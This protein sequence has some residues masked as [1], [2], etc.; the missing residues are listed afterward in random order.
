M[1][2]LFLCSSVKL[3]L[4]NQGLPQPVQ[5]RTFNSQLLVFDKT[6]AQPH[7]AVVNGSDVEMSVFHS[8]ILMR[9]LIFLQLHL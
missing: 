1:R 7:F 2:I 9:S 3:D 6:L 8:P 4:A 5:P